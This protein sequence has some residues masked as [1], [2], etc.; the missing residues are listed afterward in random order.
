MLAHYD[1]IFNLE[2]DPAF[3]L[4]NAYAGVIVSLNS[5]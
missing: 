2:N 1:V 3:I 5:I 4:A